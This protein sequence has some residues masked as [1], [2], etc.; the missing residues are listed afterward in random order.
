MVPVLDFDDVLGASLGTPTK[1][2]RASRP[3]ETTKPGVTVSS[4]RASPCSMAEMNRSPMPESAYVDIGGTFTDIVL[5]GLD[6]F[7]TPTRSTVTGM[8]EGALACPP[9][10][11]GCRLR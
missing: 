1:R 7:A 5:L 8:Q 11:F 9:G 3:C 10:S 2:L 4:P 6:C